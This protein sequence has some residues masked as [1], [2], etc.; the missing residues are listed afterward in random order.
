MPPCNG[1]IIPPH[2][3][4]LTHRNAPL[5][6]RHH[7]YDVIC[8]WLPTEMTTESVHDVGVRF[9]SCSKF[10]FLLQY[11]I[12]VWRWRPFFWSQPYPLPD[13]INFPSSNQP[14]TP[15]TL[16]EVSLLPTLTSF[17]VTHAPLNTQFF[18]WVLSQDASNKCK[19]S[20]TNSSNWIPL[21]I[22]KTTNYTR[23][24]NNSIEQGFQQFY[25]KVH[26]RCVLIPNSEH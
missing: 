23:M 17:S 24:K 26:V 19:L 9:M 8:G 6:T 15:Y 25:I 12:S 2:P 11:R 16:K 13:D 7:H 10:M 5:F 22:D 21:F 20:L 14:P 18:N 3:S 1:T 4:P